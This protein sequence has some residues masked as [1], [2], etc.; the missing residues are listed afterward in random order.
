MDIQKRRDEVRKLYFDFYPNKDIAKELHV[1]LPTIS[2]DIAE[3]RRTGKL[4]P[5]KKGRRSRFT[6]DDV[7]AIRA[8]A[9]DREKMTKQY[10]PKDA[11][12]DVSFRLCVSAR[13]TVNLSVGADC[14]GGGET[15]TW[16]C[17]RTCE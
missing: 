2:G 5:A 10:D 4:S 15:Q 9:D 12:N 16:H 11:K 6:E 1:S 7:Q 13:L 17:I 8:T 14:G 3:L